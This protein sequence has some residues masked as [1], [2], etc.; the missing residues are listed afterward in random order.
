MLQTVMTAIRTAHLFHTFDTL[1]GV[2]SILHRHYREDQ[3]WNLDSY[4]VIYDEVPQRSDPRT[5]FLQL[6]KR[7]TIRTARKRFDDAMASIQPHYVIYHN[8][9][10]MPYLCDLDRAERRIV[11]QHGKVPG[12]E[13]DLRYRREWLDGVLCV[14]KP[15]L[16]PIR[17]SLANLSPERVDFVPY[18]ITLPP[19]PPKQSPLNARPI[20][21]GVCGRIAIEQKRVD[22]LPPLCRKLEQ[23]GIDYRLEFLGEGPDEPW[24]RRRLSDPKRFRFHGRKTGRE[25]WDVLDGWDLLLSTSDYEGTPISMLEALGRQVIPIYPRIGTGGDAYAEQIHP[26]LL[27]P[28]DNWDRVAE[29]VQWLHQLPAPKLQVIRDACYAS[30]KPHLGDSYLSQFA[31]FLQQIDHWPRVSRNTLPKRPFPIDHCSFHRLAQLGTLRR[32]VKRALGR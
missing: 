3:R 28:P 17:S 24:L 18:P 8:T 22:R 1:G 27:Y 10:G 15:L 13:R 14:A 16:Q 12:L 26:S 21:I 2:E 9:W 19:A 4:F 7:D 31:D 6:T 23:S 11:V 20:V 29:T 5:Y 30:I 25:Y 32:A